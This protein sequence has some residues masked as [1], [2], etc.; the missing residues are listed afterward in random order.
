[1]F[2]KRTYNRREIKER[3][4]AFEEYL[5][6]L[7]SYGQNTSI[8]LKSLVDIVKVLKEENE[9]LSDQI[10]SLTCLTSGNLGEASGCEFFAMK[11]YRGN[12]IIFQDGKLLSNEKTTGFSINWDSNSRTKISVKNAG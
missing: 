9:A 4:D 3:I 11:T 8:V 1:M 6:K 2:E 5:H 10:D 7:D 12:P